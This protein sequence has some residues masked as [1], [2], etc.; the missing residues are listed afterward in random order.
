MEKPALHTAPGTGTP[1]A[2]QGATAAL[3]EA[4]RLFDAG[5]LAASRAALDRAIPGALSPAQRGF[6]TGLFFALGAFGQATRA[7]ILA[8][9]RTTAA[10]AHPDLRYRA[11]MAQGLWA[12][13]AR[14]RRAL[15]GRVGADVIADWHLTA[16][17]TLL[18][19]GRLGRGLY[20][21]RQRFAARHFGTTLPRQMQHVPRAVQ[22]VHMIRL[23]QGLG[24]ICLHLA[25]LRAQTGAG[26][27]LSITGHERY[28]PLVALAFPDAV[29]CHFGPDGPTKPVTFNGS[30]DVLELALSR[31]GCLRIPAPL[32]EPW[33]R[34]PARLGILWRAGSRQNH[35]D[36][37]VLDLARLLACLPESCEIVPLQHDMTRAEA[38]QLA[39]DRR[40]R[41]PGVA[42]RA[43]LVGFSDLVRGLGGVIGVDGAALHLAGVCGVPALLLMNPSAHWYWGRPPRA[44]TLYPTA[45]TLPAAELSAPAVAR[46]W[47]GARAHHA[48]RPKAPPLIAGGC[49][50]RPVFVTGILRSGTSMTAGLL[51]QAG[52]WL[53]Q[54]V[55]ASPANPRGYF[56]NRRLRET[57]V[58]PLL[59]DFLGVDP[60]GVRRLPDLARLPVFA[61]LPRAIARALTDEG[62]DGRQP[63][64]FTDAKLTLLW[65]AFAEAFPQAQW[66]I[67]RRQRAGLIGSLQ[68]TS[69]MAQHGRDP[70][71]WNQFCTAYETR[72]GALASTCAG[73]VTE[74]HYEDLRAGHHA[75]LQ[76]LA[77]Q[78][79]LN[80]SAD[81]ARAFLL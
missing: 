24:D 44:E 59:R 38:A 47:Q 17:L 28:Q 74:V 58:K 75:P 45:G 67:V 27:R 8:K 61:Q 62:Y 71:F 77:D 41:L 5:Q 22:P 53:G 10:T 63:W 56:E 35:R 37:R 1:E 78:L 51:A 31:Q 42:L 48:A 30:A 60:L 14:H 69:F 34:G 11:L 26:T 36:E 54:T 9:H 64:G 4:R 70:T 66:V 3:N 40:V 55:A 19:R 32:F 79:G 16:G 12:D 46:W 57:I 21:Y 33:Q 25:H 43:D 68:R 6:R 13:A 52:L 7:E 81:R 80:W 65:P 18:W 29:F 39:R 49:F 15:R 73:R 72:L 20:H 76:R 50:D 2:S 23:E